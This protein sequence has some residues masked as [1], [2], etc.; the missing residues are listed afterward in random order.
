MAYPDTVF[1]ESGREDEDGKRTRLRARRL[2]SA[3]SARIKR[4]RNFVKK[5]LFAVNMAKAT[6]PT[7][8]DELSVRDL[9]IREA[10]A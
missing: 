6:I 1:S 7:V 8:R 4:Y 9:P 5:Y 2:I 3:V 10:A